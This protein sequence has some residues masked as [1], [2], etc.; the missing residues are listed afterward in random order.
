[1]AMGIATQS[2]C[3]FR[4]GALVVKHGRILGA[5]SNWQK[6]DPKYIDSRFCQ[7]H[8]EIAA[9]KKAAWPKRATIYVA[10][11]NGKKGSGEPR[12]SKPCINCQEVLSSYKAKMIWTG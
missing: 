4:H 2:N 12:L 6:N 11:I 3:K 9:M 5:A 7:I 8:A 10:R 1:M